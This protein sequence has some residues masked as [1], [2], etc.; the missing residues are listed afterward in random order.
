MSP[1][2]RENEAELLRRAEPAINAAVSRFRRWDLGCLDADD[3]R[4]EARLRVLRWS[5]DG[6]TSSQPEHLRRNVY[7]ALRK[8]V[9]T[10]SHSPNSPERSQTRVRVVSLD[11]L[12]KSR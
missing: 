2:A 1:R 5:R 4:Q 6:A 3:L 8:F 11:T 7:A 12:E 10:H 9:R